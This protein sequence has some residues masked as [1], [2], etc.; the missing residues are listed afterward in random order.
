MHATEREDLALLEN[1]GATTI[2]GGAAGSFIGVKLDPAA[3]ELGYEID[4]TTVTQARE[5][6]ATTGLAAQGD[7]RIHAGLGAHTGPGQLVRQPLVD[8]LGP[9]RQ[10][11]PL[12][13]DG[14]ADDQRREARDLGLRGV[15]FLIRR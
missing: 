15:L 8:L 5:A 2:S 4:G 12:A 3:Q 6:Q 7:L 11:L 13:R 10:P 9:R 14:L 1:R